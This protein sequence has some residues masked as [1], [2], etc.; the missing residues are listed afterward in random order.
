M[1]YTAEKNTDSRAHRT[2]L[3][4]E[5]PRLRR[6]SSEGKKLQSFEDDKSRKKNSP[7]KG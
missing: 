3:R 6:F 2:R 5:A 4:N 7:K 1:S